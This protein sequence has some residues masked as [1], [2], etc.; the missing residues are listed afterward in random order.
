MTTKIFVSYSHLDAK[1]LKDS[2]LLG[3]LKGL[4]RDGARFWW[5]KSINAGDNW[6]EAIRDEI[7]QANIALVLVSQMF[8]NSKYVRSVEVNNFLQ[9][10]RDNGLIIFPVI[11]SPCNWNRHAWLKSR[12][13]IPGGDKTI[14]EHFDTPGKRKRVFQTIMDALLIHIKS[15]EK[16]NRRSS[17]AGALAAASKAVN[18][19]NKVYPEVRSFHYNQPEEHRQYGVRFEGKGDSIV[20]SYSGKTQKTITADDLNKLPSRQRRHINIFQ[21]TLNDCYNRWAELYQDRNQTTSIA[22]RKRIDQEIRMVVADM[23]ES[24]DR[25]FSF[26]ESA[27]L[28]LDDHYLEFRNVI[29]K[30]SRRARNSHAQ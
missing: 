7:R 1:Y 26:L 27:G 13:F 28:H 12:Q 2:S 19:I 18:I 23:K 8:L 29:E 4:E 10:H 20:A 9:R 17:T 21:N 15:V 22:K 3:Y 25:I 30:E 5:D 14:E 11:L 24:L 16:S 6:D